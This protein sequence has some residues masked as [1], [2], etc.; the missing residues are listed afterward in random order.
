MRPFNIVLFSS[1]VSENNGILDTVQARLNA[2]GHR[3]H[4]WRDLFAGAH[5]MDNIALLPTL[6]KKIPT[7]DFAVLICE[8]HDRTYLYR[9]EEHECVNTMRDNVLFEVGLCVMALGLSRTILLTDD[10]VRMPDDL[11]GVGNELAVARFV[12]HADCANG[13]GDM[14]RMDEAI[15]CVDA[16]V[17]SHAK[18][19]SPVV[20]GAAASTACGYV[21]NFVFRTLERIDT[22]VVL[23]GSDQ[24][25]YFPPEKIYMHII[26]PE[27]YSAQTPDRARQLMRQ[28]RRGCVPNARMRKAEFFCR[29]EGDELH[30]LDYP[31]TLVTSYDTARTILSLE[32]DDEQDAEARSRFVAKEMDLFENALETVL[33]AS[34]A[35]DTVEH[36]YAHLSAPERERMIGQ[37][38]QI[39]AR[40]TFVERV[41]Y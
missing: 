40:R 19:I 21:S 35:R 13:T 5:D 27:V 24:L 34:F 26:L 28:L 17:R 41:D 3:C 30:I 22:G 20:I 10:Q 38:A 37:V 14:N 29:I 4:Y 1:G 7:F 15:A 39:L 9:G 6:I 25:R 32:A 33:T 36:N 16:Y 8:G 11:T 2:L 18:D 31:T 23:E 12:Y